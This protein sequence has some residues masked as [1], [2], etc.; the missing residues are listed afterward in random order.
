MMWSDVIAPPKPRVLR[1]FAGLWLVFFVGIAAWR[2]WHGQ[3]GVRTDVIGL[4]GLVVGVAGL[5]APAAVRYIYTGWMIAA[6]PIGWTV[7]RVV[8]AVVF[9]AIFAPVAWIFKAIGR[10]VLVIRRPRVVS[11]WTP[12]PRAS[13]AEEYLRQS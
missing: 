3:T 10:D 7:S 13:N 6:F 4:L 1:Q 5:A 9:Y 12:K 11:Y 2:A 8:L